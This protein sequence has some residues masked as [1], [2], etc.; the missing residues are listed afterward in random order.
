MCEAF[1]AETKEYCA[2]LHQIFVQSL[3]HVHKTLD[4]LVHY[5]LDHKV[6]DSGGVRAEAAREGAQ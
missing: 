4:V 6:L 3:N 5:S 2:Q 1:T